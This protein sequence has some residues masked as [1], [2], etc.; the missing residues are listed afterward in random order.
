[1]PSPGTNGSSDFR[2]IARGLGTVMRYG[3]GDILFRE[4]DEPVYMYF[5]LGGRVEMTSHGKYIETVEAGR[6]LGT[7]S[8]VDKNPRSATAKV[9]ETAEIALIDQKKFR[10]MVE[11]IPGF[12]W[13][14]MDVLVH[15][16]R[17]TNEAL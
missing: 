8:M 3:E 5:V 7:V 4:G 16:L 11:E 17:A 6:A 15:R 9:M 1:M 12:C 13:F 14:V 10:F 2:E